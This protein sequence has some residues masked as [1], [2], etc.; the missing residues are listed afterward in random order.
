MEEELL[1]L[2]KA[3]LA[4]RPLPEKGD[5]GETGERGE[6][7]DSGNKGEVGTKGAT[8]TKGEQGLKGE[9]GK[10]GFVG[11]NG[12]DGEDG[13]KGKEGEKGEQGKKGEDGATGK[14]G[15]SAR[16]FGGQLAKPQKFEIIT[17]T[18]PTFTAYAKVGMQV[19][20]CD[21]TANNITINLRTAVG[22]NAKIYI[23]KINTSG[24]FVTVDPAGSET[25]DGNETCIITTP[26]D[27]MEIVSNDQNW[28]II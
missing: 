19:I 17:V 3:E 10:G 11:D 2:I 1:Q 14:Q 8:G 24:N 16:V 13:E 7:G 25:I 12:E 27:T 26:F 4:K 5:T 20:L 22:N 9:Q 15:G 28:W 23:K 6:K 21:C 18:E